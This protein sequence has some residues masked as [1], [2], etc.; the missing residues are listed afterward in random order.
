M[1]FLLD[2]A[3]TDDFLSV[4][5]NAGWTALHYAASHGDLHILDRLLDVSTQN[6]ET[7]HH[8]LR[9]DVALSSFFGIGWTS[10][11]IS[12]GYLR[13]KFDMLSPVLVSSLKL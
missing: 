11:F 12:Q 4:D 13:G 1:D 10:V 8:T 7:L 5:D 6:A 9:Y 2:V 3:G